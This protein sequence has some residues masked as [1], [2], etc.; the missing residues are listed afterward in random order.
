V[1]YKGKPRAPY[2]FGCKVSLG[3]PATRPKGGQFVLHC[4]PALNR[5]P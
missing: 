2:E 3:T 5:D 1:R 4:Q